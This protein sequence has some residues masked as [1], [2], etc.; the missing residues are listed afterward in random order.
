MNRIV[1]SLLR[2]TV[3]VSRSRPNLYRPYSFEN[4]KNFIVKA[5]KDTYPDEEDAKVKYDSK[6]AAK[7]KQA[8]EDREIREKYENMTEEEIAEVESFDPSSR[9]IYPK[10]V[11]ELWSL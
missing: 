1:P 2:R 10:I 4:I 7:Q 9:R 8:K 11:G 3:V 5:W 6:L